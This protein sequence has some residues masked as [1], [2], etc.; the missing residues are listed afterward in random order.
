GHPGGTTMRTITT[1]IAALSLALLP[2]VGD[3]LAQTSTPTPKQPGYS[4]QP[5][6]PGAIKPAPKPQAMGFWRGSKLIRE[7]VRD[8]ENKNIGKIEDLMLD[9]KGQVAFAVMSF[10]GFMGIGDKLFAVP[11]N[12]M[13]F[14][15]KGNDVT[16]VHLDVTKD[17]LEKAPS[18]AKDKW[19]DAGDPQWSEQ[20]RSYWGSRSAA[21]PTT[22]GTTATATTSTEHHSDGAITAK[23]KTKLAAEKLS[24]LTN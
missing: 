13:R 21:R 14:E 15:H 12:A 5:A 18:F 22:G 2:F 23:V 20:S 8:V 4:G 19:P 3:T 17:A 10:G 9:S 16:A 6:S 7:N 24:T 1:V 11:W